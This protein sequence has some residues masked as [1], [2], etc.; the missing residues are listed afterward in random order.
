[1]VGAGE[2]YTE[3]VHRAYAH[4]GV[5]AA[6]GRAPAEP[7]APSREGGG[8]FVAGCGAVTLVLESRESVER[9]DGRVRGAIQAAA[10]AAPADVGTAEAA[11]R[12]LEELGDPAAVVSSA[13]GTWIDRI[14]AGGLRLADRRTGRPAAVSSLYGH[15]PECFSAGPVAAVAAVLLTGRLP[16]LFGPGPGGGGGVGGAGD[17]GGTPRAFG[18]LCTDYSGT[19]SGVRVGLPETGA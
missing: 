12:V 19:I 15:I 18:V 6:V 14:E 7:F 13:N 11:D 5:Y 16:V 9:R 2:E 17:A 4:C 3:V 8:G 10:S 1:V